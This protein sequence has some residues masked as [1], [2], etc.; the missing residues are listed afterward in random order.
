MAA[1][2]AAAEAVTS[3]VANPAPPPRV[4]SRLN[5]ANA[6]TA[7]RYLTL[8][9][10]W[11]AIH[12]RLHH[13]K[14][15]TPGDPHSPVVDGFWHGHCGWLFTRDLMY[16]DGRL[17]RDLARHP[18]LAWLDR[19]W[20]LPGAAVAAALIGS[21]VVRAGRR[22]QRIGRLRRARRRGDF[23]NERRRRARIGNFEY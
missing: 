18:E 13:Q 3:A 10:L 8:P 14:S 6:V 15:D 5:P 20:M 19:V 9:P 4:V 21:T 17:V 22:P 7:S 2:T 12:H 23:H 16:P 1:T 11:W